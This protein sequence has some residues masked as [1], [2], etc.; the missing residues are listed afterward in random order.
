MQMAPFISLDAVAAPFMLPNLDTDQIIPKQF[1]KIIKR[2][3]LSDALFFE[4]RFDEL[5]NDR[6]EFPLNQPEYRKSQILITGDNFGCGSSREHAV[7]AL[8]DFGIRCVISTS[9]SDI[10]FGSAVRNGLLPA[11]VN[12]QDLDT[13]SK[14]TAVK[15]GAHL[16]VSLPEQTIAHPPSG[17]TFA[18]EVPGNAKISLLSGENELDRVLK[19]E[20][21][22]RDFAD[23]RFNASPWTRPDWSTNN[24]EQER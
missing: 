12:Q 17:E 11:R 22:I 20:A 18:F 23:R 3:D 16:I 9:F 19:C 13:L 7:W 5:G 10:F 14:L 1:M 6:A 21:E 2:I 15:S 24:L 4:H 8:S